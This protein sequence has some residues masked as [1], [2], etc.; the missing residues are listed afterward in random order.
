MLPRVHARIGHG[1]TS[2]AH[3][4]LPHVGWCLRRRVRWGAF[5]EQGLAEQKARRHRSELQP[6]HRQVQG[7]SKG[8]YPNPTLF[9]WEV[10]EEVLCFIRPPHFQGSGKYKGVEPCNLQTYRPSH[11]LFLLHDGTLLWRAVTRTPHFPRP[12]PAIQLPISATHT[13]GPPANACVNACRARPAE[14]ADGGVRRGGPRAAEAFQRA[15]HRA[16]VRKRRPSE[17][18]RAGGPRRFRRC[19]LQHRRTCV[20]CRGLLQ[21]WPQRSMQ[22]R[23][24]ALEGLGA[25][26]ATG[27]VRRAA[28]SRHSQR[29][30]KRAGGH[31]RGGWQRCRG[32]GAPA[33]GVCVAPCSGPA[34]ESSSGRLRCERSGVTAATC[35]S[36]ASGL[37]DSE[38]VFFG[39]AIYRL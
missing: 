11:W 30:V 17:P 25:A 15:A 13:F 1:G 26:V 19:C 16:A 27:V 10:T 37:I 4:P 32:R 20:P 22:R 5:S 9:G 3:L 6:A 33:G 24:G 14:L 18:A 39:G 36:T 35:G 7:L 23:A 34:A 21:R 28:R 8:D 31:L 12:P 2:P 38:S 29:A